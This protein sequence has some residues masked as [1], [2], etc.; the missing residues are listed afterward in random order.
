MRGSGQ[1]TYGLVR[2]SRKWRS[3]ILVMS[4]IGS[5]AS[6]WGVIHATSVDVACA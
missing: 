6:D 1:P 4:W 5:F 2:C 3:R